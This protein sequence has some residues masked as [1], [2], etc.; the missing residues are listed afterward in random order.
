MPTAFP[1]AFNF[2]DSVAEWPEIAIVIAVA[3]V[4]AYIVAS[5]FNRMARWLVHN[6]LASVRPAGTCSSS[7]EPSVSS[8][9]GCGC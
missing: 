2:T 5:L 3:F 8:S 4:G 6:L 1:L 7:R 9:S